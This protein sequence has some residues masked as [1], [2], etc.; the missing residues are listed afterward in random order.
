MTNA[1]DPLDTPDFS[2]RKVTLSDGKGMTFDVQAVDYEGTDFVYVNLGLRMTE[3]NEGALS[4]AY[5]CQLDTVELDDLI[6][7]LAAARDEA[8][9]RARQFGWDPDDAINDEVE[10]VQGRTAE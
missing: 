6:E 5:Q 4:V 1:P 8:E 9:A 7:A 3:T 10:V 2:H